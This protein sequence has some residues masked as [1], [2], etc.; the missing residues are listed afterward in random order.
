M[1]KQYLGAHAVAYLGVNE[2]EV[3]WLWG[4]WNVRGHKGGFHLWPEGEPDPTRKRTSER[5]K[6]PRQ[7]RRQLVPADL[8]PL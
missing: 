4:I 7:G 5:I 1:L 8:L 3:L 2:G 6:L